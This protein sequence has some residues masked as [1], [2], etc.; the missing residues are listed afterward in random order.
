MKG[1]SGMAL[2]EAAEHAERCYQMRQVNTFTF[3]QNAHGV[4]IFC[5]CTTNICT[6]KFLPV[7]G[8]AADLI[9]YIASRADWKDDLDWGPSF[10]AV[11]SGPAWHHKVMVAI[12]DAPCAVDTGQRQGKSHVYIMYTPFFAVSTCLHTC[13]CCS[14]RCLQSHC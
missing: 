1:Q 6:T 7:Q 9:S 3:L 13:K 5:I 10:T 4:S 8:C 14:A 11:S 12:R 2:D